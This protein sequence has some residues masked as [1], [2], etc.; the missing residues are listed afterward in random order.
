VENLDV[1]VPGASP[2]SNAGMSLLCLM[3]NMLSR[4]DVHDKQLRQTYRIAIFA[5][6]HTTLCVA[7]C[8]NYYDSIFLTDRPQKLELERNPNS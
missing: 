6:L 7:S 4:F 2:L 3:D 8:G 1:F 5:V